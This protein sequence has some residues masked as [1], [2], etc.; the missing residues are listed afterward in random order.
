MSTVATSVPSENA[1]TLL[2][3]SFG[4]SSTQPIQAAEAA[5][6][7]PTLS[8]NASTDSRP[9]WLVAYTVY[10]PPAAGLSAIPCR[11]ACLGSSAPGQLGKRARSARAVATLGPYSL[12]TVF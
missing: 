4:G 12:R 7:D 10:R 6:P 3:A 5:P 11:T 1:A 9:P 8:S 2:A